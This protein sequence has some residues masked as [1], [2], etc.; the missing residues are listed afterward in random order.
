VTTDNRTQGFPGEHF[1]RSFNLFGAKRDWL[2]TLVEWRP[3]AAVVQ[4][5]YPLAQF[6]GLSPDRWRKIV[7]DREFVVFVPLPVSEPVP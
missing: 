6:M 4:K 7:E 3:D 1:E 2:A 5:A